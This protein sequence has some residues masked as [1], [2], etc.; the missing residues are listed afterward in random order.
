MINETN[1]KFHIESDD[2]F[3]TLA[4]ILSLQ[5]QGLLKNKEFETSEILRR[6]I[7]EL[8]YLQKNYIIITRINMKND[9]KQFYS[10]QEL[11]DLLNF[12][13][14][15]IYRHIKSGKLKAYKMSKEFRISK[16]D[17]DIFLNDLKTK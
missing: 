2:Y 12:N 13:V 15:T 10:A 1:I 14:M 5:E 11:A 8:M 16:S 4:T 3:A 17:F 6:K 9:E 7:D